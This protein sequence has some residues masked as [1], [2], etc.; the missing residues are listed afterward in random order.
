MTGITPTQNFMCFNV[1]RR[2]DTD[3]TLAFACQYDSTGA[4]YSL[5]NCHRRHSN[6]ATDSV[7]KQRQRLFLSSFLSVFNFTLCA[8]DCLLFDVT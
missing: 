4:P 8:T 6:L 1:A 5:I 7:F 2:S 3:S